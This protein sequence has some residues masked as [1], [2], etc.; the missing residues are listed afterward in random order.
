[1]KPNRLF[2]LK[3]KA[4]KLSLKTEQAYREYDKVAKKY[5]SDKILTGNMT[6]TLRRQIIIA[7]KKRNAAE[8]RSA[9]AWK[10]YHKLR[11][12]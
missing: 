8:A 7:R 9:K 6:K 1:M 12:Y 11:T 10:E 3:Y 4:Q 5:Y 2:M